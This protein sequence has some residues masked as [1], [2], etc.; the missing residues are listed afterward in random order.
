MHSPLNVVSPVL[1]SLPVHHNEPVMTNCNFMHLE[2]KI[3]ENVVLTAR[4]GRSNN[5]IDEETGLPQ[6]CI[7]IP[8][9]IN[10]DHSMD[11][12]LMKSS[13]NEWRFPGGTW[14]NDESKFECVKRESLEEGGVRVEVKKELLSS[15]HYSKKHGRISKRYIW[16]LVEIQEYFTRSAENRER[17]F[18]PFAEVSSCLATAEMKT[19][20]ITAS[21]TLLLMYKDEFDKYNTSQASP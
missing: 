2:T 1:A 19:A 4:K 17:Q 6:S 11:I 15:L 5:K 14:E 16:F 20:W 9:R 18:F 7:G 8:F 10:H 3:A 13:K 21:E 12:L